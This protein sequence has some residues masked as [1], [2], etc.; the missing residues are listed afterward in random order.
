MVHKK[1]GAFDLNRC[2][3]RQLVQLSGISQG[4][5]RR[6]VRFRG[7]QIRKAKHMNA[8][9]QAH[10]KRRQDLMA[11]LCEEV[12]PRRRMA[13]ASNNANSSK[14][15]PPVQTDKGQQIN[16]KEEQRQVMMQMKTSTKSAS[17]EQ[18][19][20]PM[21]ELLSESVKTSPAMKHSPDETE[22][23]MSDYQKPSLKC[24]CFRKASVSKDDRPYC[25]VCGA[26]EMCWVTCRQQKLLKSHVCKAESR[27]RR[28]EKDKK[29][30][31]DKESRKSSQG[32]CVLL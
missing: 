4:S 27:M 32:Q 14:N 21:T 1:R 23:Y 29:A 12:P 17:N 28:R 24:Q 7:R 13:R 3:M 20:H 10:L 31:M 30:P 19:S 6:L 8:E 16:S 2:T 18:T 25:R 26:A 22:P 11:E 9:R 15:P 5:A